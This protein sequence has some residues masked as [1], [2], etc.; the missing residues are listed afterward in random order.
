MLD[1]YGV[2]VAGEIWGDAQV[3]LGIIHRKGI[4]TT[5]HIQ[6][7][8]LWVQQV[9]AEKRFKFGKVLGKLNLADLFAKYFDKDNIEQHVATLK[10]TFAGGRASEAPKFHNVSIPIDEYEFIGQWRE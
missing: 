3:A 5:R 2:K 10:Y 7:G 4:G 1:D 6:T 8:L 9:S